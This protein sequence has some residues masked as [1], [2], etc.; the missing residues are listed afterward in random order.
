MEENKNA[1]G[2]KLYT[3][4]DKY[5]LLSYVDQRSVPHNEEGNFTVYHLALENEDDITNYGIYA[6]GLLVES[7]SKNGLKNRSNMVLQ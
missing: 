5:R 6:N 7:C 4:D 3:T 2:G 1:F